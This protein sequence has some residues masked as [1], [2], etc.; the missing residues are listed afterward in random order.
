MAGG[1]ICLG[2]MWLH[3][4]AGRE[5]ETATTGQTWRCL[6]CGLLPFLRALSQCRMMDHQARS[7]KRTRGF[8]NGTRRL[9]GCE[10]HA[11][12]ASCETRECGDCDA[13]YSRL[14]P[15]TDRIRGLIG[16]SISIQL[17]ANQFHVYGWPLIGMAS[18]MGRLE[19]SSI[20]LRRDQLK[21]D[22]RMQYPATSP[23]I[24]TN[25]MNR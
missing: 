4:M 9:C 13:A 10:R 23:Q 3:A 18:R 21:A 14:A 12:T 16:N 7:R 17:D 8:S 22:N 20:R 24:R 15:G 1:S 6:D 2:R 25:R 5:I 19:E 11:Q